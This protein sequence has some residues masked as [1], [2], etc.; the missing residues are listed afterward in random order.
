MVK[1][2][3]KGVDA[4]ACSGACSGAC[5]GICAG[6]SEK[7]TD[8]VRLRL[9]RSRFGSTIRGWEVDLGGVCMDDDCPMVL[10]RFRFR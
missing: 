5:A 9:R 3:D 4:G 6:G 8:L 10:G 2:E 7:N 1:S